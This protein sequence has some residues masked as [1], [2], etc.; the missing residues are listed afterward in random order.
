MAIKD[1]CLKCK[2]YSS[3]NDQC[4]VHRCNPS[5]DH[6][7]CMDYVKLER[8]D[9]SKHD[10]SQS[11]APAPS[12]PSPQRPNPAPVP[13]QQPQPK[14]VSTPTQPKPS[15]K[16]VN[17]K[18]LNSILSIACFVI[19]LGASVLLSFGLG[20]GNASWL[21][22]FAIVC[23]LFGMSFYMSKSTVL[24][25]VFLVVAV[26]YLGYS[27]YKAKY[28][29]NN[30][31]EVDF[32]IAS[33]RDLPSLYEEY[34]NNFP[35][36]PHAQACKDSIEARKLDDIIGHYY[37]DFN[38]HKKFIN[39]TE[40]ELIR[41]RAIKALDKQYSKVVDKAGLVDGFKIFYCEV[42]PEGEHYDEFQ[43]DVHEVLDNKA[44]DEAMDA[45][46]ADAFRKYLKEYPNGAHAKDA[47][48][49]IRLL[50]EAAENA[51]YANNYLSTGSQPYANIYGRNGSGD[52]A[53]SVNA[54]GSTDVV[55]IVK[56]NNSNGRVA[57]HA[58]IRRGGS[59]TI[60]LN[61]GTYQVFFYYGNG[62]NPNKKLSN[63]L[64]GGFTS[65]E[66]YGKDNPINLSYSYSGDYIYYD[67]MQYSLQ[68]VVGGNFSM[69]G[70]NANDVF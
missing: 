52:C 56:H 10:G 9:L 42:Y 4:N 37:Y 58:Y 16:P 34:I 63:G 32:K 27:G 20:D 8:I 68:S 64:T 12:K 38:E 5:Y 47:K 57:G 43:K 18:R 50:N 48:D 61:P 51:K 69:K 45:F 41:E 23:L 3:V 59:Y 66:Q 65:S 70:S 17:K 62:W 54:S 35:D 33:N 25:V 11:P 55:V 29:F 30:R 22:Y 44:F 7:S 2:W 13:R 53:V 46:T 1:Q 39:N 67:Q 19:A 36:S 40:S 15:R 21:G 6:R 24:R 60:N 31:E 28:R 26:A 14:P 49:E